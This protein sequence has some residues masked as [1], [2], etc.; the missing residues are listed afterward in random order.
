MASLYET[1]SN[2]VCSEIPIDTLKDFITGFLIDASKDMGCTFDKVDTTER[3][4][5]I[6]SIHYHHLPLCLIASAFKRGALGQYGAGRLVP[7]TIYGWLGEMN[8]YFLTKHNVRDNSEDNSNKYDSL[9]KY[10]LGKAIIKKIDWYKSG[11]LH[12]KDWEIVPLKAV[13]E[14]IGKGVVPTLEHFNIRNHLKD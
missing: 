6:I 14:L 10:P 5:Y 13:A 9:H 11:A 1:Y 4:Y 2:T 7:K 12:M 3:V 8:Q